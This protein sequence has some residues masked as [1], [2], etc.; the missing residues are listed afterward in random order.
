MK[1][2]DELLQ[3]EDV[4]LHIDKMIN[5]KMNKVLS[6]KVIKILL[7]I[8]LVIAAITSG[9]L[10]IYDMSCYNPYN[11]EEFLPENNSNDYSEFNALL[12]TYIQMHYPGQICH[13]IE[14]YE[15]E[16]KTGIGKYSIHTKIQDASKYLVLSGNYNVVFEISN[17]KLTVND[18]GLEH[19][20]LA[21]IVY[22]FKNTNEKEAESQYSDN[23]NYIY[24]E[25]KELPDSA[26][27]NTSISFKEDLSLKQII[28]LMNEYD[29]VGFYWLALQGMND[30]NTVGV[31]GGMSLL[32]SSNYGFNEES[33]KRYPDFYVSKSKYTEETL[34]QKYLSKLQLLI[35]HPEFI[36]VMSTYFHDIT[37]DDLKNR[38]EI[39]EEQMNVYGVKV[40]IQKKDL[41]KMIE[42]KDISYIYIH[43][44]K[45]SRYSK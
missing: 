20:G 6:S 15:G 26:M 40:N 12:T 28:E 31:A 13:P 14:L 7:C 9:I 27:I 17:S 45:L 35:D 34:K 16:E 41:L 30:Y 21:R 4:S 37:L 5:K 39:A 2:L 19:P 18:Y 44:I 11:E 29:N 23:V 10:F 24:D 3:E 1:E 42:E 32:D 43:D 22:E 36:K 25:V 38:K 33:E 8:I